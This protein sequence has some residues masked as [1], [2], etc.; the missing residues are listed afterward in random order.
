MSDFHDF[1]KHQYAHVAIGEFKPGKFYEAQKLYEEAVA[2][3]SHGFKAAYFLREPN[4]ER[5]IS[6]ILWESVDDLE[7]SQNETHQAILKKMAPLFTEIPATELYEV[8]F[9]KKH[10]SELAD[11]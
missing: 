4:S 7:A 10:E 11:S 2:T 5:G 8:V 9:E 6:V 3:Y 1:L